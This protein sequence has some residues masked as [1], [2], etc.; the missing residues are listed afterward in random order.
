MGCYSCPQEFR[1]A[2]EQFTYALVYNTDV[3]LESEA[4]VVL[5]HPSPKRL[6]AICELGRCFHSFSDLSTHYLFFNALYGSFVVVARS[7]GGGNI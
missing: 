5:S 2:L 7:I 6:Q 1:Y 4:L 3:V